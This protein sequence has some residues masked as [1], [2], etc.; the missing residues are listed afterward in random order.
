MK[1]VISLVAIALLTTFAGYAQDI[2]NVDIK[3][4]TLELKDGYLN[5]NIDID[6][7][8]LDIKTT[9]VVVLTPKIV[10]DADTL[11]LKSIGV[12]GR[13]RRIYYE[14]NEDIKP[15]NAG[16][17]DLT[18]SQTEDII[19][20]STTVAF[21]EWM[22]GCSVQLAR[23]DY[24]CCGH[25][26]AIAQSEVV[27]KFPL[28]PYFPELIYLRP[29]HEV[30]KTREI[31]GSAF[32]D[33][34][35]SQTVIYPTYRNNVAEL[36][37]ITG[38][39][40]SVKRD[41]DITIKSVFIKGFA[42]PESPYSN[43]TR[44]AKGR[45]EALKAYVENMYH[46]GEG[47]IKT[48]FEPEDWAGL[49]RYVEASSLPHKEEILKAIRSDREPD[50]KEWV[51]KSTW[52]EEYRY[53][54][55]NCYPALRHSD[56]VIE[57]EVKSYADPV[58]IERVLHTA[59]QNLSLEEFYILAQTYE[60]GSDEFNDLFETAVRMYPNDPVANLNAANSAILRK[61]YRGALRFLD[62][63]GDLPEAVYARGALEIY[64]E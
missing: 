38:T 22:N 14:R 10:K 6:L 63:A 12:Y 25:S 2:P 43:N 24:G 64:M 3:D 15:T 37:K 51:I 41:S 19:R 56:Y 46:F 55:D 7:S 31:S 8:Q 53:L 48:D 30:V 32:V 11:R 44:L 29:E 1:R 59:P 52:K 28:D 47:F 60:S 18:T 5:V 35:V 23:R 58:E 40:D 62:K 27:D 54:L 20:Y 33:F 34:P 45:T 61:D 36:A 49:E 42:S 4:F 9:Q 13:N 26:D 39:I 16:D 57:Y 21:M 50:K 17:I